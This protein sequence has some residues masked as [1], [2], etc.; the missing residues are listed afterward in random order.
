MRTIREAGLA[1]TASVARIATLGP[2][3][4]SI[5]VYNEHPTPLAT[6]GIAIGLLAFLLLGFD[7]SGGRTAS[8]RQSPGLGGILLLVVLFLVMTFND[9]SMKVA[10]VS[11]V[12]RGALLSF[13]FG[14]AGVMSWILYLF[15][16]RKHTDGRSTSPLGRQPVSTFRRD[17]VRGLMLG[18]PNF[19]SSWFLIAALVEL[20][21][22]VVFPITSAAGVVLSTLAAVVL[23]QERPGRAGWIGIGLASVAVVLLGLG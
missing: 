20:S 2:V 14:S 19:F 22:P 12:D 16:R 13:V 15:S 4:L 17:V 5:W 9:F 1:I 7:R 21:G 3:L 8:D 6:T 11:A 18:V 23:W 10:E